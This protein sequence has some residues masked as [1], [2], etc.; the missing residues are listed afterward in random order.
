MPRAERDVAFAVQTVSSVLNRI[1]ETLPPGTAT[2]TSSESERQTTFT[3]SPANADAAEI[4]V[5]VARDLP[6]VGITIGR[7]AVYEVPVEGHRYT[8][9]DFGEEI[10]AICLAA[11]DGG[12]RETV[13]YKGSDVVGGRGYAHIGSREVGDHWRKLLSNPLRRAVKV[14]F[15]YE[16]YL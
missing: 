5:I 15:S 9:L 3:L 16:P 6:A 13:W 1:V 10:R 11:V 14:S 12:V 8:D 7:G 2:L 4:E